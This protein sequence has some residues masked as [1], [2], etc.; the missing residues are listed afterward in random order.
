MKNYLLI[1]SR[2]EYEALSTRPFLALAGR[3]KR[4][5]A[6]VEIMLVQ[7]G[8][9]AARAGASAE[10]LVAAIGSG[11]PVFADAFALEERAIDA[12][13][14]RSGVAAAPLG[15]IIERMAEGWNVVW[16]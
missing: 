6:G 14:L 10:A 2:G 8:V 15:R 3:L 5:G 7:N 4:G 1:E 9:M 16:H 13:S 12:R 11:A